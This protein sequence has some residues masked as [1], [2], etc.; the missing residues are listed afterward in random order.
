MKHTLIL[1]LFVSGGRHA[2]GVAQ[3]PTGIG[4]ATTPLEF[5]LLRRAEAA[6]ARGNR[7]LLTRLFGN[8][9][10]ID[11]PNAIPMHPAN[12]SIRKLVNRAWRGRERN[13][14]QIGRQGE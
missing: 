4:H 9:F 2:Q 14:K 7:Q 3:S 6:M 5:L 11:C 13:L 12:A 10:I 8:K 1:A